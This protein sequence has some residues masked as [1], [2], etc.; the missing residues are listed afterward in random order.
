[1][2]GVWFATR[3]YWP[4]GLM[5][6]TRSA[7]SYAQAI[8]AQAPH[9]IIKG[10]L[11]QASLAA[12]IPS[13]TSSYVVFFA[14]LSYSLSLSVLVSFHLHFRFIRR[15]CRA[16]ECAFGITQ[17]ILLSVPAATCLQATARWGHQHDGVCIWNHTTH[18]A[19]CSRR[20]Y[21]FLHFLQRLLMLSSSL[22]HCSYSRFPVSTCFL[23]PFSLRRWCRAKACML[24]LQHAAGHSSLGSPVRWSVHLVSHNPYY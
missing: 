21:S 18:A 22:L 15:W 12:V 11:K 9:A 2:S 8:L 13:L 10:R 7:S 16:G 24:Q 6:W 14:Q 19:E 3:A 17:S 4:Q 1:M 5:R 20:T 23:S